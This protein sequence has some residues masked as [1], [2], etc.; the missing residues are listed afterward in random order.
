MTINGYTFTL[1]TGSGDEAVIRGGDEYITSAQVRVL[2]EAVRTGYENAAGLT[3][4]IRL[5]YNNGGA[6]THVDWTSNSHGT[7]ITYTPSNL[8]GNVST[9]YGNHILSYNGAYRL[10]TRA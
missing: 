6:M 9:V 2:L 7:S 5:Y 10:Y 8:P 3:V 1:T 4:T